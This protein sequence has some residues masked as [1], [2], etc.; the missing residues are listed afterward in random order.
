VA[1]W[2]IRTIVFFDGTVTHLK[3]L[4]AKKHIGALFVFTNFFEQVFFMKR[5]ILIATLGDL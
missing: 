5:A 4:L 1:L 3:T 2:N